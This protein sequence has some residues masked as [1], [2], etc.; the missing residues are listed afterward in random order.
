M[1]AVAPGLQ[2]QVIPATAMEHPI[3]RMFHEEV[4]M[5][6]D[7]YSEER[8]R[9]PP[10]VRRSLVVILRGL[11]GCGKSTFATF[12]KLYAE[13]IGL[14]A[15]ICSADSY[16]MTRQ[17]YDFKPECLGTAHAR[18]QAYC[19]LALIRGVPVVIIDNTNVTYDEWNTYVSLAREDHHAFCRVSF[20][21]GNLQVQEL[22]ARSWH[23]VPER[24]MHKRLQ[25]FYRDNDKYAPH[26]RVAIRRDV[27]AAQD[28]PML[29]QLHPM[30]LMFSELIREQVD[31]FAMMRAT[32]TGWDA[33]Q[34]LVFVL[35]GL[36]GCGKTTFALQ[37]KVYAHARRLETLICSSDDGFRSREGFRFRPDDLAGARA[38]CLQTVRFALHRHVPVVVVDDAHI[39]AA[40][41]TPILAE[42]RLHQIVFV[43][44]LCPS[45]EWAE[46]QMSR[47]FTHRTQYDRKWL[48]ADYQAFQ[49]AQ[50]P[51]HV[52]VFPIFNTWDPTTDDAHRNN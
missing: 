48:A 37:T 17:G 40:E 15:Q 39:T 35:R 51:D 36:P 45:M 14:E 16:F 10:H 25:L 42:V 20:E 5:I 52:D 13:S 50:L 6:I 30:E 41:W 44:F 24:T 31:G 4:R 3:V 2:T 27:F 38:E 23:D 47:T 21:D 28:V 26:Y 29:E 7:D 33:L 43:N 1:T 18:C 32:A 46:A 22:L 34:S 19:F 11:P 8:I 9:T 12:L 49:A